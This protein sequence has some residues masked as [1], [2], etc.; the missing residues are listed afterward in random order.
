MTGIVGHGRGHEGQV[1]GLAMHT[2]PSSFASAWLPVAAA[3]A[4]AH[5]LAHMGRELPGVNGAVESTAALPRPGKNAPGKPP[6]CSPPWA[7]TASVSWVVP[8]D[9]PG[10]A[11][12]AKTPDDLGLVAEWL[13]AFHDEV[14]PTPQLGTGPSLPSSGPPAPKSCCGRP[15]G[16][17]AFAGV[18]S[19][20]A[21]MARLGPVYTPPQWRR[22]GY[23]AAVT[24]SWLPIGGRASR[25]L[26]RPGQA[27]LQLHLPGPQLQGRPR[28]RGAGSL[29]FLRHA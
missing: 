19:P 5:A 12:T 8:G 3:V 21:G 2:S 4:L 15:D 14:G 20:A 28:C 9:V 13:A 11:R 7:C 26:H 22:H 25:A 27:D 23:R 16:P 17:R 1:V 18:S 29:H 24:S 6:G 10:E